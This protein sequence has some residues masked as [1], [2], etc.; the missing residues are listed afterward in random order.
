MKKPKRKR[1]IGEQVAECVICCVHNGGGITYNIPYFSIVYG[2]PYASRQ[3]AEAEFPRQR[4]A[5]ARYI[6]RLIEKRKAELK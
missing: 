6:D 4:E 1:T 2:A 3:H 5:L